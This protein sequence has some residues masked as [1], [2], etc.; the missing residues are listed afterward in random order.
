VSVLSN[1]GCGLQTVLQ[2]ANN[3]NT[4]QA[5]NPN[6]FLDMMACFSFQSYLL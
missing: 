5:F 6:S 3:L 4:T 2:S 1:P